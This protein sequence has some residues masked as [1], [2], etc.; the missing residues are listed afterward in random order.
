MHVNVVPD[1]QNPNNCTTIHTQHHTLEILSTHK[2][3]IDIVVE[4]RNRAELFKIEIKHRS[5]YC[6]Q[7]WATP[8]QTVFY[9][10]A[11]SQ[12]CTI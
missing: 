7:V 9:S 8:A 2:A 6:V 1:L 11:D 12:V 4:K 3:S 5:V 10:H